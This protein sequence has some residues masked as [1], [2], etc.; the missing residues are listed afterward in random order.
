MI[1]SLD[2]ISRLRATPSPHQVAKMAL[3]IQRHLEVP[4]HRSPSQSPARKPTP[5]QPE[6]W[7]CLEIQVTSTK[8][9]RV[10]PP[11]THACC[12]CQLWKTWFRDGKAGLTEAVVTEP[13]LGHP[14]L[15]AA[16][17]R[18]RTE[19]G[20]GDDMLHSCIVRCHQPNK[21]NSV[22]NQ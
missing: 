6:T 12:R 7:Y 1:R 4:H 18:R 19:F 17:I 8:D 13:R 20:Q 22:P 9:E 10:T 3:K 16:V 14:V 11:P 21:P 2:S 15:Q 5:D